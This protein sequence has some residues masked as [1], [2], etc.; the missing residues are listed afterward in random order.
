V[1]F[2]RAEQYLLAFH[3]RHDRSVWLH[4]GIDALESCAREG[5]EL[6]CR[7][8]LR[9]ELRKYLIEVSVLGRLYR[10][11]DLLQDEASRKTNAILLRLHFLASRKAG[12]TFKVD[13]EQPQH[14]IG[15]RGIAPHDKDKY[16]VVRTPADNEQVAFSRAKRNRSRGKVKT[17]FRA[18]RMAFARVVPCEGAVGDY[19]LRKILLRWRARKDGSGGIVSSASW[20]CCP[21]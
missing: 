10:D 21:A 19:E 5:G 8:K 12:R 11:A 14:L 7:R 9:A 3:P 2:Q 15:N 13:I 18:G 17:V 4:D 20:R 1:L 16:R 6:P